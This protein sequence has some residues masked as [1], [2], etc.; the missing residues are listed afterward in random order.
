MNK[1]GTNFTLSHSYQSKAKHL[2]QAT[3]M[4]KARHFKTFPQA[5]HQKINFFLQLYFA[6]LFEAIKIIFSSPKKLRN[7]V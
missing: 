1:S 7:Q 3:H 6:T 5:T 4:G 2:C